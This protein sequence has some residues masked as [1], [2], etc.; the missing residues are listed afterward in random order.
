MNQIPTESK[1]VKAFRLELAK[2]IPRFPNDA[3]SL[4]AL[5]QQSLGSLLIDYINWRVRYVAPRPRAIVIEPA[6]TTHAGWSAHQA[7]V[8]AFLQKVEHGQDLTPHLSLQPHTRGFTPAA[9][10]PGAS[11]ED[12]WADKDMVLNVMGYHHFHPSLHV[13]PKGF[14]TRTDEIVLAHVTRDTFTVVGVFDHSVFETM[15]DGSLT[16]ERKRLYEVFDERNTRGA[17]TGAVVMSGPGI[18]TSGHALPVIFMAQHYARIVA[19]IDPQIDDAAFAAD[20]FAELGAPVPKEL[21]W[22]WVLNHL[23]LGIAELNSNSVGIYKKGP[24]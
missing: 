6:V 7:A 23:D 21:K 13:E 12:R 1:R 2:A 14:V 16:P 20:F 11:V 8:T 9:G 10:V 17:P 15:P 18:A 19:H 5:Q 3:A 24:N 22:Q 4:S